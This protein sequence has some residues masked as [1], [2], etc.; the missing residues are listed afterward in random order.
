MTHQH[1]GLEQSVHRGSSTVD[2]AGLVGSRLCH[3]LVSPLGAVGNGVELLQ[4][5]G[6]GPGPELDLIRD[7]VETASAKLRFYRVAFGA[8]GAQ[9]VSL[10]ELGRVAADGRR[11]GR[12]TISWGA[13]GTAP[14]SEAR[15]AFLA[16][17]CIESALPAGGRAEIARGKGRWVVSGDGPK[18][19]CEPSMWALLSAG[20]TPADLDPARV[21]FAFAAAAAS[22]LGVKLDVT[23]SE[24]GVSIA[25]SERPSP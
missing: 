14:R 24:G 15:L 7:G 13:D 4:M 9:Q 8:G 17:L 19:R 20:P 18:V 21:H 3:D 2:L 25:F 16:I 5:T 11:G 22:T 23:A 1:S 10:G 6:G 12:V